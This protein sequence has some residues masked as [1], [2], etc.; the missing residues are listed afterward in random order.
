MAHTCTT[1]RDGG[2]CATGVVDLRAG[3]LGRVRV[4]A[5]VGHLRLNDGVR[6]PGIVVLR[7]GLVHRVG[8]LLLVG[9]RLLRCLRVDD[10]QLEKFTKKI[11]FG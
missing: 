1:G 8:R 7:V 3:E 4:D 10:R 5:N 11:R 9:R 2:L 6:H